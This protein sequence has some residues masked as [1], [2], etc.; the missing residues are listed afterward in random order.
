[1]QYKEKQ[2]K[3]TAKQNINNNKKEKTVKLNRQP[4]LL[5]NFQTEKWNIN[6]IT[7]K[8]ENENETMTTVIKD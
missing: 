4:R 2:N 7:M 1:M 3:L 8:S 5:Y 6:E